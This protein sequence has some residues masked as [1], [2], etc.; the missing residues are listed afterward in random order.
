MQTEISDAMKRIH[1]IEK[2]RTQPVLE[3]DWKVYSW[4]IMMYSYHEKVKE[5]AL[6]MMLKDS[7]VNL[8]ATTTTF[9]SEVKSKDNQ[10]INQLLW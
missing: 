2:Q 8:Q 6:S 1:R 9:L 7:I 3:K 10:L 4:E 5:E